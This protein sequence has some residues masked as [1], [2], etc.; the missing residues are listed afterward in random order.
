MLSQRVESYTLPMVAIR[1]D[2]QGNIHGVRQVSK[3]NYATPFLRANISAV[4]TLT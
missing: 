1:K 4:A 3:A 2:S